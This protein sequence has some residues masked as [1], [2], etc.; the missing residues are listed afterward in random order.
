MSVTKSQERR[1][2]EQHCCRCN[3]HRCEFPLE[4]RE[5]CFKWINF[6]KQMEKDNKKLKEEN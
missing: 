2:I 3:S 1:F 5:G 4:W 6:E